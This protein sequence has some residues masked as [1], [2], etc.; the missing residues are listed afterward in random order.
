MVTTVGTSRATGEPARRSLRRTYNTAVRRF[1]SSDVAPAILLGAACVL[2][3]LGNY[4]SIYVASAFVII[5]MVIANQVLTPRTLPWVVVLALGVVV[6]T[7]AAQPSLIDGR[8]VSGMVLIFL[9]GLIILVSSFRRTSLGVA[10]ARGE[11]MLVD[12]R[13]RI[14]HQARMPVMPDTW[15]AEAILRSAGGSSFAGDFMVAS[16]ADEGRLLQ[17]AVVDVSGK[18]VQAGSRSLLLSG[19]LGG[20][21]GALPRGAVPARRERVP[22]ASE[23]G[24]G[25]RDGGAR[26]DRPADR[27]VPDP[28]SRPPARRADA[29]SDRTT[30]P[31]TRPRDPV[32]GLMSEP[33]FTVISGYL[34]PGDALMLFTDGLVETPQR[35][36]S[37]GVEKLLSQGELLRESCE[38]GAR[39]L[40]DR[41]E[42]YDD[43]RALLL[44]HRRARLSR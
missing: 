22:A 41:L 15:Y 26:R 27:R 38:N 2:I 19:A 39:K 25:L 44:L 4:L 9:V 12:L 8:R 30:G 34:E 20:L 37:I 17:V 31:S 7:A 33:E 36:V 29:G 16:T 6:V 32:L 10:G 43:D 3:G 14:Q 1:R 18:G 5:P 24:R 28:V 21:L 40:I 23:V 42:S 11:T 13:D 35:D